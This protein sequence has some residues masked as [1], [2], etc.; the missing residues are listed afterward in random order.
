MLL[1]Y[2]LS[3]SECLLSIFSYLP[4][5]NDSV[6]ASLRG[7]GRSENA[8]QMGKPQAT[9]HKATCNTLPLSRTG[10]ELSGHSSE[11]T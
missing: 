9:R 2:R 8:T 6:E 11:V 5:I 1:H 3:K 10:G 7:G 4:K